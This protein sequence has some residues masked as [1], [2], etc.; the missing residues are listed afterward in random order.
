MILKP[1]TAECSREVRTDLSF[2]NPS[3]LALLIV[4]V[5]RISTE[6][7][8]QCYDAGKWDISLQCSG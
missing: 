6:N 1:G 8:L 2:K 5:R 4:N 3:K 7:S